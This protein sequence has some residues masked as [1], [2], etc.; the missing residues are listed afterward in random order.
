MKKNIAQPNSEHNLSKRHSFILP[1]L[2]AHLTF[3]LLAAAG[4]IL[5]LWSKSAVFSLLEQKP[6]NSVSII[7]GFLHLVRT[8]NPGA[9][10]GILPGQAGLFIAV[11][12]VALII[13]FTIF[14]FSGDQH[15]LFHIA[16]A[17]FAAGVC[18]NLYDRIFNGGLV[19]DFIDVV[20]YPGRHWP[21]FNVADA[22]LCIGVGLLIFTNFVTAKSARTRAQQHK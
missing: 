3:W 19:R 2:K 17:L 14:L 5:D 21:A 11:S 9:L 6:I 13:I 8:E 15:I 16:L 18:G 1:T 7:Q 20:Y 22:M 12:V 10:F 4:L